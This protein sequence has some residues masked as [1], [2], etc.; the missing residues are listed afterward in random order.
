MELERER[1]GEKEIAF[2]P[3]KTG[4]FLAF[5]NCCNGAWF[6][7]SRLILRQRDILVAKCQSHCVLCKSLWDNWPL[8]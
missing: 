6:T 1:G 3:D 5:S 7:V 4:C 8:P 2:V